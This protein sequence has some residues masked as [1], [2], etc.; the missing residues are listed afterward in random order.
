MGQ[1]SSDLKEP[2]EVFRRNVRRRIRVEAVWLFGSRARGDARPDSDVDL[3]VVS[4]DFR[5]LDLVERSRLIRPCWE[6]DI[7][8]DIL[9]YT[10]EEFDR[11][12][13][14]IT[15]VRTAVTEGVEVVSG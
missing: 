13:Q 9:P 4:P 14:G 3:I 2:L 5:G 8:V 11:L 1:V 12:R 10:P 15:L 6:A 7:S